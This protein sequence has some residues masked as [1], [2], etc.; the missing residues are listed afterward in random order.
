MRLPQ[1]LI[2]ATLLVA[3]VTASGQATETRWELGVLLESAHF[4]RALVDASGHADT[5]PALRP[6][7]G[8][9]VALTLA[10]G[11]PVW[12]GE[13]TAGWAGMRP[14]ADNEA[15]AVLDRTT[16]LTRLRLGAALAGRLFRIGAGALAVGA[17]PTLDWWRVVG[18]DRVRPGGAALVALR[19]P[20]GTWALE[21]RLAVGISGS[22][23]VPEDIGGAYEARTLVS[24][25]LGVALRAPL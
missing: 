18:D 10:R 8:S 12:R 17:G 9:G 11:G 19:L 5:A 15:V 4:S 20:L 1:C 14:Q 23:F 22:P 13:V 16:L 7:P 24:L 21:N 3:P 6:S 25:T 2:V